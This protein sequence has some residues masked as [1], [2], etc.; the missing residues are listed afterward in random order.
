MAVPPVASGRLGGWVKMHWSK[1]WSMLLLLLLLLL[2]QTLPA[3][4]TSASVS[5]EF[6][7]FIKRYPPYHRNTLKDGPTFR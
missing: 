4:P 5:S 2:H 6:E 7:D 3:V 1:L